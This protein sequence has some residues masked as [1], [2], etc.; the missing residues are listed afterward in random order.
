MARRWLLL[1][2]SNL[3]DDACLREA[4]AVLSAIGEVDALT[5]IRR[6][7]SDD[8][9]PGEYYNLLVSLAADAD[10]EDIGE[11]LKQLE[12]ALGRRRGHSQEVAIDIDILASASASDS[13]W[14]ADVH[15]VAKGE[16]ARRSV[17]ALLDE[18]GI[19]GLA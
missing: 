13:P 11:R 1:L 5:P 16:F 18:T 17:R 8:G 10:R 6:F 7:P 12:S 15:A 4:S 2:G 9:S 14:Q 19:R 3:A